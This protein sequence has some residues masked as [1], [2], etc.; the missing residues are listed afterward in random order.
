[1]ILAT[2]S[3]EN[4]NGTILNEHIRLTTLNYVGLRTGT[5]LIISIRPYPNQSDHAPSSPYVLAKRV[6]DQQAPMRSFR[7]TGLLQ[8]ADVGPDRASRIVEFA[9]WF[10]RSM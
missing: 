5:A 3:P 8:H 6:K 1:M 4:F 10:P 2:A 7:N 9:S